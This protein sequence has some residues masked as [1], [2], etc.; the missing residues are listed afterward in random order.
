MPDPTQDSLSLYFDDDEEGAFE[1]PLQAKDSQ[2]CVAAKKQWIVIP[3]PYSYTAS[4][5]PIR[6]SFFYN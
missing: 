4:N 1:D 6:V 2:F 3:I 5:W